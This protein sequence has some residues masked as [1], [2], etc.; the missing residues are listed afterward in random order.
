MQPKAGALQPTVF[1]LLAAQAAAVRDRIESD[2]T[3]HLGLLW[4]AAD[5][6]AQLV[7]LLDRLARHAGTLPP[8][9]ATACASAEAADAELGRALDELAFTQA[10][11]MDLSR[12]MADGVV[13][14]LRGLD[15]GETTLSPEKISAIY[16]SQE[17]R[18]VHEVALGDGDSKCRT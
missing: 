13:L 11:R 10:Q 14:A 2:A 9:L 3:A 7:A 5:T 18:A 16:V 12:Q 8:D 17:Q 1:A 15:A 4:K 6:I